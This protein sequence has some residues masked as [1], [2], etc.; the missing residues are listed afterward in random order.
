MLD[1]R[2]KFEGDRSAGERRTAAGRWRWCGGSVV[3]VA[4][5]RTSPRHRPVGPPLHQV[6][7]LALS[8]C[9]VAY[10]RMLPRRLHINAR[11]SPALNHC[12]STIDRV[13]PPTTQHT[14]KHLNIIKQETYDAVAANQEAAR[15]ATSHQ[16]PDAAERWPDRPV[17]WQRTWHTHLTP[18]L[19][20]TA[21]PHHRIRSS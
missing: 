14:T 10:L 15:A 16:E 5:A 11:A 18:H 7:L 3:A 2:A 13:S 19:P 12:P 1:V 17:A 8:Q 20:S 21:R 6:G 9:R 4:V